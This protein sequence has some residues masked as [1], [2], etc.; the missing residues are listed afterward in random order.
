MRV[1]PKIRGLGTLQAAMSK[2]PTPK[3]PSSG[4]GTPAILALER[5]GVPFVI[6]QFD[7]PATTG[8]IGYGKAAANALGVDESRVF[9]TLLVEISDSGSGSHRHAVGIVPVSGSLSLKAMAIAVGAKRADMMAPAVAERLT[10][11]VVGGISPFGQKKS[12]ITV[13][14]VSATAHPTIFVSGGK[15]GLDI[16]IAGADLILVLDAISAPIVA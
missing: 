16:E 14:D 1:I 7:H 9:K 15:R 3:R 2:S 10:G 12:S 8:D 4:G 13:I 5:A 6:H 11:Y